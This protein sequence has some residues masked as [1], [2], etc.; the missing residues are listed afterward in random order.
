MIKLNYKWKVYYHLFPNGKYY[1]GITSE[2]DIN[3]RFENGYGYYGQ[4]IFN[5]IQKYGWDNIEHDLIAANLTKEEALNFESLLIKKLN[6]FLP[7]GY[8][9]TYGGEG[10]TYYNEND[11]IKIKNMYLQGY[12][13]KQIFENTEYGYWIINKII[14]GLIL[15]EQENNQIY[16]NQLYHQNNINYNIIKEQY[17]KGNS[18][19]EIA[20]KNNCC[21]TTIRKII[22]I[23]FTKEEQDNHN[24][25]VNNKNQK[26][27]RIRHIVVFDNNNNIIG[28]YRSALAASKELQIDAK[29]I[30]NICKGKKGYIQSK[31][32]TFKFKEEADNG[33]Y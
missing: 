22:N 17:L 26:G 24:K 30:L 19:E 15:S 3:R 23:L 1:I 29:R 33:N 21:E 4:P 25:N 7:N 10:T 20:N 31:G 9:A 11:I 16:L 32:Y 8:N 2:E 14:D 12:N 18:Y 27:K 6:T 5:A 28:T 13:K